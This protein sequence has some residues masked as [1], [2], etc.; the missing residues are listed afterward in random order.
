MILESTSPA[1]VNY[2]QQQR[3]FNLYYLHIL[4]LNMIFALSLPLVGNLQRFRTLNQ[5]IS[6]LFFCPLRTCSYLFNRIISHVCS[7]KF[8]ILVILQSYY[9]SI[10]TLHY[11]Y[12]A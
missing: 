7:Y 12:T 6:V 1:H 10:I 2:L 4:N 8:C 9:N 5:L 11:C 3:I